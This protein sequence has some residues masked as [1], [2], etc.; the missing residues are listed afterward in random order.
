M[1]L[2]FIGRMLKESPYQKEF[3][4]TPT[5]MGFHFID[6]RNLL[7]ENQTLVVI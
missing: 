5:Y 2:L 7:Q 6:R 4:R 3:R 1:S